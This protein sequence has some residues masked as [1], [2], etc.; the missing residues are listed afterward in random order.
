MEYRCSKGKYR[1]QECPSKLYLLYHCNSTKVSLFTTEAAHDHDNIVE[2]SRGLK[3]EIKEFVKQKYEEGIQKPN[4]LL[5]IIR[6]NKLNEPP[7]SKLKSFLK[8]LRCE[9]YGPPTISGTEITEWCKAREEIP[10]D[11]DRPFVLK[12]FV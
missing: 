3:N 9:K 12:H 11:K 2:S 1:Q 6:Q 4:A 7:K 5:A 8:R 10:S